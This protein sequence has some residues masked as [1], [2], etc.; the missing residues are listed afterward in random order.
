MKPNLV[1]R[2]LAVAS[3]AAFVLAALG[4]CSPAESPESEAPVARGGEAGRK[5]EALAASYPLETELTNKEGKVIEVTII[6][7]TAKEV[8]FT[9]KG[10]DKEV[11]FPLAKL[12]K[13]DRRR[14]GAMPVGTGPRPDP[15]YV[16]SR[17]NA[18]EDIRRRIREIEGEL[19][20][21][22]IINTT[23]NMQAKNLKIKEL[24]REIALL[25]QQISNYKGD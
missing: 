14:V 3:L 23:A 9:R 7:R 15:P 12:S 1:P 2:L 18:L 20:G 21:S 22:S 4:A 8:I 13:A 6:G 10:E 5:T 16:A 19:A 24:K 25:E 11:T 17:K